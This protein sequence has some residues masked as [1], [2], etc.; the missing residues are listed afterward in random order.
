VIA[1]RER[2]P[3]ELL[4]LGVVRGVVA[5]VAPMIEELRGYH[6]SRLAIAI[7]PEE[8]ASYSEQFVNGG[9]EPVAP[10]LPTETAEVLALARFGEVRVPHA[11]FLAALSW[12]AA[13][14]VPVSAVDPD[15]EEYSELFADNIGYWELVRR[16]V[17]E[18]GLA[19][20]PPK[21][22]TPD[23]FALTWA[24]RV[25]KGRASR[26]FETKRTERTVASAR[27]LAL[28]GDRLALLVDRERI[29][30]LERQLST[31]PSPKRRGS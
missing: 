29:P 20:A 6:P 22:N 5:E 11:P 19:R 31:S 24:A 2:G 21:A 9:V 8:L 12:A 23:E 14:G 13:S 3:P 15:E 4:L 16:T 18:R 25:G 30:E 7:G 17:R 26:R 10:L 28:R 1:A 27:A